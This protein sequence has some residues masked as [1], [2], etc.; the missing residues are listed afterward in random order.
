MEKLLPGKISISRHSDDYVY[1]EII[2]KSTGEQLLEVKLTLVEYAWASTGLGH[3]PCEYEIRQEICAIAGHIR[4][5][6][7]EKLPRPE[8]GNMKNCY[9]Q[10]AASE[11]L[12]PYEIDGWVARR[13][14]LFNSHRWCDDD[15]VM[16]TFVR[17]VPP[18]GE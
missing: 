12:A 8:H 7:E 17:F 13:S 1:I 6:K 18:R 9:A 3:T 11:I 15:K 2:D 16:V 5:V 4:E 14:D 10:V